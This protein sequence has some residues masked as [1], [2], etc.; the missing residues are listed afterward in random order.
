MSETP[1]PRPQ[2]REDAIKGFAMI[3]VRLAQRKASR[4]Q[5]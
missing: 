5:C 1:A 4:K 3:L 2:C